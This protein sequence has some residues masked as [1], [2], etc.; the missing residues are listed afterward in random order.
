MATGLPATGSGKEAALLRQGTA[1]ARGDEQES[2]QAVLVGR[3][4]NTRRSPLSIIGQGRILGVHVR[5][6]ACSPQES[7]LAVRFGGLTKP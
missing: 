6:D 3:A 5:K 2:S 1:N 4:C 7:C